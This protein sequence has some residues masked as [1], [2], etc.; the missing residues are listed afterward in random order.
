MSCSSNNNNTLSK[1]RDTSSIEMDDDKNENNNLTSDELK[2]I[3]KLNKDLNNGITNNDLQQMTAILKI[4]DNLNEKYIHLVKALNYM[5]SFNSIVIKATNILNEWKLSLKIGDRFDYY[6]SVIDHKWWLSEIVNI[7]EDG[8][9]YCRF[10][11]LADKWN[12]DLDTKIIDI[13]PPYT[14]S[15]INKWMK[16]IL[17]KEEEEQKKMVQESSERDNEFND[18][19]LI[20]NEKKL[21]N[22]TTTRFGRTARGAAIMP[23][24]K[25]KLEKPIENIVLDDINDNEIDEQVE[26]N[27]DWICGI[28]DQ[29]EEPTGTELVLCDGACMQSFHYG[30]LANGLALKKKIEKQAKQ[31]I[32]IDWFCHDCINGEHECFVCKKYGKDDLEVCKCNKALCGK[33][34]HHD[35]LTNSTTFAPPRMTYK[36]KEV[37][38]KKVNNIL[39]QNKKINK[40]DDSNIITDLNSSVFKK[41]EVFSFNCPHHYCDTCETDGKEILK[42]KPG[43][44]TTQLFQCLFCPRAYHLKCIEP[45]Y[46][47][48]LRYVICSDHPD[49]L[50]PGE[51]KSDPFSKLFTQM[52]H[53]EE[54]PVENNIL[55]S[56]FRIPIQFE[57]FVKSTYSQDFKIIQRND[58]DPLGPKRDKCMPCHATDESCGCTGK[59]NI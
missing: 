2:L 3:E 8:S 55:D 27:N 10:P 45:G 44:P 31:G 41:I 33:Y 6:D 17:Q 52:N 4:Y 16:P 35:C 48:D 7:N 29:L 47:T 32:N 34:Y 1:K 5:Y 58:Y 22:I 46:R 28:C 11:P 37:E 39:S 18:D 53:W 24:K 42:K 23:T 50:L 59:K 36:F 56:H 21:E 43:K 57:E 20:I 12:Q 54:D 40:K 51:T 13:V 19:D 25:R 14:W 30:C 9:Y 26:D 15:K 38:I 49:K